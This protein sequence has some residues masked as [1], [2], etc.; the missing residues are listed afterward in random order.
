[1]TAALPAVT[2]A[3]TSSGDPVVHG[4]DSRPVTRNM[5]PDQ[6]PFILNAYEAA[7]WLGIHHDTLRGLAAE[8]KIPS[9]RVG[10]KLA[11]RRDEILASFARAAK[12]K[13]VCMYKGE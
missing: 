13:T 4:V 11:F 12:T 8:Q 7:A 3:R 2:P 1:M 5:A 10:G 6:I 9:L